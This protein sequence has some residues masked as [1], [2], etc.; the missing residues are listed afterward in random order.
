VII[1][2]THAWL[3]ALVAPSR[4]SARARTALE[5]D[6]VGVSAMSCWEI[7]MLEAAGRLS[8]DASL[9][10]WVRRSR[11]SSGVELLDVDAGVAVRAGALYGTGFRGDP[12]DMLIAAT[13]LEYGAPL[14]SRDRGMAAVPGLEV[15]W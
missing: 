5:G 12:A 14:V 1:A 4:L 8:L 11:L 2:D 6:A 3:W 9:D 10:D 7:G 13:A 15:I